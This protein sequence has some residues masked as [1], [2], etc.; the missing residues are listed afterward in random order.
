MGEKKGRH[1]RHFSR[2]PNAKTN[3]NK[4][5][6]SGIHTDKAYINW[7]VNHQWSKA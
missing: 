3:D 4:E 1:N 2:S 7:V 5:A 6:H